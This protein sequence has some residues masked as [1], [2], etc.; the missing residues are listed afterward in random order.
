DYYCY[1]IDSS[2]SHSVF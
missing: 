1:S 2:G